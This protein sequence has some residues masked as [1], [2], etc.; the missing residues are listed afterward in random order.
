MFFFLDY[1][2]GRAETSGEALQSIALRS[3][4]LL[5][6]EKGFGGVRVSA[7]LPWRPVRRMSS[8]VSRQYRLSELASLHKNQVRGSLSG[9]LRCRRRLHGDESHTDL[10][11]PVPDDRRRLHDLSRA[12]Q[13]PRRPVLSVALWTEHRLPED[14]PKRNLQVPTGTPRRTVQSH[15]LPTRVHSQL[16]LSGRQKLREQ[17][18]HR[19]VPEKRLRSR[20]TLQIHQSQPSLLVSCA[21]DRQSVCRMLREER[22]VRRRMCPV[23]A[24]HMVFRGRRMIFKLLFSIFMLKKC[25]Y[26]FNLDSYLFIFL[27]F[28][29]FYSASVEDRATPGSTDFALI[30][31]A[32]R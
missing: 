24:G 11:V 19:S 9:N 23:L 12:A 10:F 15:R 7:R 5:Q 31:K 1:S 30:S 2:T 27:F 25:I 28:K 14:R 16:R 6:G 18:V 32:I 4:H 29:Y 20:S 17:Q 13:D 26:L 3:Q 21:A 22:S 8:G